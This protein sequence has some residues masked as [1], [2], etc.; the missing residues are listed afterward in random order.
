[1]QFVQ[2]TPLFG[3]NSKEQKRNLIIFFGLIIKLLIIYFFNIDYNN[4]LISF[5]ADYLANP[6]I[7][8]WNNWYLNSNSFDS[9][10]YGP[11]MFIFLLPFFYVGQFIGISMTFSY[12][13][14]LLFADF[15]FLYILTFF[16]KENNNKDKNLYTYMYWF[17][18]LSILI[19]YLLGNNDLIPI[20]FLFIS[21]LYIKKAKYYKSYL[22]Y[23]F[24]ILAKFS[25][26]VT[27]PFFLIFFIKR[28]QIRSTLIKNLVG[29]TTAV[30]LTL[31]VIYHSS[32]LYVMLSKSSEIKNLLEF[33][34]EL[35]SINYF[36]TP[37]IVGILVF[38][39][40]KFRV[41]NYT[42]L[43]SGIASSF[44]VILLFTPSSPGWLIW[45]SPF[46]IL[47][48]NKNNS[49]KLLFWFFT[50]TFSIILSLN[51]NPS[52]L[53]IFDSNI[54][55]ILNKPKELISSFGLLIGVLLVYELLYNGVNL[56]DELKI[57]KKPL[58]IGIAGDSST[59]KDTIVSSIINLFPQNS[60]QH[61]SGDDYH[62]WDR[63]KQ[64]WA[65][66]THLNP[67]ANNLSKLSSDLHDLLKY[68]SIY[69]RHYDHSSGRMTRLEKIVARELLVSSGLHTLYIPYSENLF[70]LRVFISMNDNL[71]K[72]LKVN[73]D[74]H[75]RG[76]SVETVL[77]SIIIREKDSLNYINIQEKNADITF[78]L[79]TNEKLDLNNFTKI[80]QNKL[81]LTVVIKNTFNYREIHETLV[82]VL[83]LNCN[84]EIFNDNNIMIETNCNIS[85]E[86]IALGAKIL[87]NESE[88]IFS[89]N[90]VWEK[91][92]SGLI[93]LLILNQLEKQRKFL[94]I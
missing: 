10:P 76:K 3:K 16:F 9:F 81:L 91:N 93:Q 84:L 2:N 46:L 19:I 94:S 54:L 28:K 68:K 48:Y 59:G 50:I 53:D 11:S 77:N 26:V 90:P 85:S 17:N 66:I 1:M 55:M 57:N 47:F 8:P 49:G 42:I 18:P 72:I 73:R 89:D 67:L 63:K 69:K 51:Y 44:L 62:L 29:F 61:I 74:V 40:F 71:R 23:F 60:V 14:A 70:D 87:L 45:L 52:F 30:V 22:F 36:I 4:K 20:L 37:I 25:I 35:G 38:T 92:S 6:T 13:L 24:A 31:C 58:S 34:F 82:G 15:L 88:N 78:N 12:G 65:I 5:F 39:I 41:I 21:I 83:G 7:D 27:F 32:G 80:D 75:K 86:Q 33:S 56:S 64:N 43:Y 79:S